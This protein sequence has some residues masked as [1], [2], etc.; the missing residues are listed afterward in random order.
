[1]APRRAR[2]ATASELARYRKNIE[3]SATREAEAKLRR[4]TA[5]MV[6]AFAVEA[7]NG[8]AQ[9]GPAWTG[10]FSQSWVFGAEGFSAGYGLTAG[11]R[12]GIGR[13]NKNDA[14]LR[15]IESDLKQGKTIFQLVNTSEHA[16]IAIDS[17]P[18]KFSPPPDAPDPVKIPVEYG[19]GRPKNEHPRWELRNKSG[20]NITS[21]ITAERDWFSTYINGGQLQKNLSDSVSLS[22]SSN[23]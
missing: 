19:T 12:N 15:R 18:A 7:M 6:Q 22:F 4:T 3:N 2:R 5:L 16:S 21:Q 14:P 13:Y 20:E 11:A 10:E 9:A 1:M 17:E 8:L 23:L